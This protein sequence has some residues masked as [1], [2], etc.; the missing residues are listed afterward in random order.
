MDSSIPTNKTRVRAALHA[1]TTKARALAG[2]LPPGQLNWQPAP[3]RWSVGQCLDHVTVTA[4]QYAEVMQPAIVRAKA[5]GRL[6]GDRE[7]TF[8][9]V[10]KILIKALTAPGRRF[11]TPRGVT[12]HSSSGPDTI[13]E[14]ERAHENLTALLE[15]ARDLAL[16]RIKTHSPVSRLIRLTVADCFTILV[17]LASRHL[18]QAQRIM[19][20]PCFPGRAV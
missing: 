15:E 17:I 19:E 2:P 3:D 5:G 12:P 16:P 4:R 13:V 7:F 8:S 1:I 18:Q 6:A 11:P 20:S 10:G 14:F 9:L